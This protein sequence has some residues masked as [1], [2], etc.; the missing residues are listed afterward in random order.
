MKIAQDQHYQGDDWWDWSVWIDADSA[1]L[2]RIDRVTW[3]L[4]PTF[5]QPVRE[6]TNRGENFRLST[7]GWG[8][9]RIRADVDM[10][11]GTKNKLSHELELY[12]PDGGAA[13]A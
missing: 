9:F 5:P 12:Y 13:P 6:Q 2:A 4:H 8:T 10:N 1:E 3:H 11:D 7:A